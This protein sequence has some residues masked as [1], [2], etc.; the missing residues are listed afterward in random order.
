[1]KRLFLPLILLALWGCAT[2]PEHYLSVETGQPLRFSEI[3]SR[4]ENKRVVFVGERHNSRSDHLVQLEVIRYLHEN[5]QKVA[6]ALEMFPAEMQGVLD[7]WNEGSLNEEGFER[8][9]YRAWNEPFSYYEDI[10]EYARNE[11]IPLI[12]ING[13]AGQIE[14][15]A[16][17]GLQAVP[18]DTLKKMAYVPCAEQP[19]YRRMIALFFKYGTPHAADLP[20]FCDAQRFRDTVMAYSIAAALKKDVDVVVVLAGSAHL[21]K[22][23]VPGIMRRYTDASFVVLMSGAFGPLIRVMPENE[24]ADYLWY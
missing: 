11:K 3:L 23:A 14:H 19:E 13:I 24:T 4:V 21:L 8:A 9:Y 6:I 7:G 15:I 10:F 5:G 18:G 22:A 2:L 12:G 1:M 16:M 17:M 20:F